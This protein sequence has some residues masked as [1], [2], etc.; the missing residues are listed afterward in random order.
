MW[1]YR[2]NASAELPVGEPSARR[3]RPLHVAILSVGLHAGLLG[4]AFAARV[5]TP[6]GPHTRL[7]RVIAGNVDPWT[8]DFRAAGVRTARIRE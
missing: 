4:A 5:P 1:P 8:G 6:A 7:V 3:V 2:K